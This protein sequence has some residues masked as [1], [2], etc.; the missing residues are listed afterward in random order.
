VTQALSRTTLDEL[1]AFAERGPVDTKP[2]AG[3]EL[4]LHDAA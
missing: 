1:V 3:A 2:A 4:P